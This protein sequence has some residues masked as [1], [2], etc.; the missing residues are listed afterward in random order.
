M[1]ALQAMVR[2]L[3]ERSAVA[4]VVGD[5]GLGKSTMWEAITSAP[6]TGEL[7]LLS[8]RPAEAESRSAWSGLTDLMAS[9]PV[10]VFAALPPPQRDA[11]DAACLRRAVPSGVELDPRAVWVA[12]REVVLALSVGGPV[13]I[14]VDDIHWLDPASLRALAFLARR[15]PASGVGVLATLRTAETDG[16]VRELLAVPDA[17]RIDLGPIG[18]G[19]TAD[20]VQHHLGV[21]LSGPALARVHAAA[22][23]NPMFAIE[24]AR[25]GGDRPG[26]P[27]S[28]PAS[29]R[30]LLSRR[31]ASVSEEAR[32]TLAGL[33]AAIKPSVVQLAAAALD[34]GLAEAEAADLAKVE[35]GR[36]LLTHPLVGAAAYAACDAATRR[37]VHSRLAGVVTSAEEQARHAALGSV[38]PGPD[39]LAALDAA[40]AGATRRGAPAA[41]AELSTLALELTPDGD[42]VIARHLAAGEAHFR[43]GD[44]A[45]ARSHFQ[46]VLDDATFP[47]STALA[48]VRMAELMWETDPAEVAAKYAA[49]AAKLAAAHPVLE[50]EA[51]LV[52]SRLL[53]V[54][55]LEASAL[56]AARAVTL[57]EQ[58]GGDADPTL[59]ASALVAGAAADFE[60]GRGLDR[61]C[62]DRAIAIERTSPPSRVADGA[63]AA[64]ASLLKFADDL[65]GSRAGLLALRV[66]IDENGDEG[67]LPFVLGHLVALELLAGRW[68]DAVAAAREHLAL[69]ERTGQDAQRRQAEYNLATVAA[70]RGDDAAA[71]DLASKLAA[72]ARAGEDGWSEMLAE[73]VLGFIGLCRG[74][75][76]GAVAHFEIGYRLAEGMRLRE[77]GRTRSRP[78]H[79]ECLIAI[80]E[81]ARAA[82]LLDEYEA[83]ASAVDRAS[84][85]AAIERCRA[86]LAAA[87][88]DKP[89]A[90]LAI[91]RSLAQYDRIEGDQFAFERARSLLVAGRLHR[92]A[93][94]KGA[95]RTR[96]IEARD[97]F[98]SLGAQR[99]VAHADFE[100]DRVGL[101]PVA[102]STLSPVERRI[103]ELA[104]SGLSTRQVADAV[105][106][107]AK[108]VEANVTRIYRKLGLSSRA[109]LGAWVARQDDPVD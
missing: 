80:G 56:E 44:A 67:S 89:A 55:D 3:P 37:M 40:A 8:A 78:D 39:V 25:A 92:R 59:L 107:S 43:S 10:E 7:T 77:P 6:T 73:N 26:R 74:D 36:A 102:P 16:V 19:A 50:A 88:G 86:L 23:G 52:L 53:N 81:R 68:D 24:L 82:S 75:H 69:A 71:S 108:T 28:V 79:V 58:V 4:L 38:A 98:A 101:R 15:L 54:V 20:V 84:A 96:L 83:R 27:T 22:G 63:E 100:M 47:E 105:F 76:E 35:R 34:G 14:A 17:E 21:V 5:P 65:Q 95:A 104:A 61:D 32:V 51:R 18:L 106:L 109:E 49:R 9:V 70:H 30:D 45:A 60:F 72:D 94:Q 1:A 48:A 31:L 11:L 99:F 12:M 97:V 2:G 91:D 103:A 42:D 33:A 90:A 64:L 62:F 85:L 41:A 93:K 13:L 57:L 46:H 29:L 87:Q 66:V